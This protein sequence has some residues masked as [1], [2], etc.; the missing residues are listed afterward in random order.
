MRILYDHQIFLN[1]QFGGINRYFNEIMKINEKAEYEV[2]NIDYKLFTKERESVRNKFNLLS[3][4][5]KFFKGKGSREGDL[6]RQ[7]IFPT[8]VSDIFSGNNFDIFHP[9]YYDPYFLKL[10]NKPYV[11]TVHDM[12][13][14][15]Y[16]EYLLNDSASH[17]KFLLCQK[18]NQI[19]AVSENTKKDLIGIF[20]ILPT[21]ISVIPLASD[22]DTIIP[23]KPLN[24]IGKEKFILYVGKR[25]LYKNF[26]FPMIAL[27]KILKADP[28]LKVLCTG[29][30]FSTAEIQFFE[31]LDIKNQVY[32]IYLNNDNELAWIYRNA[33]L[34][35][36]PSLYEG[37]GLPILEAFATDCPVISSSGG[38]LPEVAGDAVIYFDPKSIEEIQRAASSV[39]YNSELK[40]KLIQKGRERFKLFSWDRCRKETIK[41]YDKVL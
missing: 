9:T 21:K 40:N 24:I 10:T 25:A 22:F 33:A 34:F 14:E 31:E 29:S 12:I 27:T 30:G 1:Q 15:L 35:I 16:K 37:F 32:H 13:H 36:F 8:E 23:Q 28:E 6:V 20:N 4:S 11:L 26:Y 41:V 18:A 39:L 5:S 2:S 19:I 17:N 38:S 7:S 3:R